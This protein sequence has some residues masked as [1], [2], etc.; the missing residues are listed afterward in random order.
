M[1]D[2]KESNGGYNGGKEIVNDMLPGSPVGAGALASTGSPPIT[3][4]LSGA[5]AAPVIGPEMG[6]E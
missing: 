4:S 1:R 3:S 5:G 2:E 6:Q